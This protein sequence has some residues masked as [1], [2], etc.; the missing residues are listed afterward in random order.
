MNVGDAPL[1]SRIKTSGASAFE[2]EVRK[3]EDNPEGEREGILGK[4]GDWMYNNYTGNMSKEELAQMLSLKDVQLKVN[5]AVADNK[6]PEAV[7]D[8]E[9]VD[10]VIKSFHDS[11]Q[12]RVAATVAAAQDRQNKADDYD[13][14]DGSSDMDDLNK[15]VADSVAASQASQQ[16][17]QA[18]VGL[19]SSQAPSTSD[20][21]PKETVMSKIQDQMDSDLD[22]DSQSDSSVNSHVDLSA[23]ANDQNTTTSYQRKRRSREAQENSTT[24]SMSQADVTKLKNEMSTGFYNA[25]FKSEVAGQSRD[26]KSANQYM[27]YKY[28]EKAEKL[29]VKFNAKDKLPEL[30]NNGDKQSLHDAFQVMIKETQSQLGDQVKL[31]EKQETKQFIV[32]GLNQQIAGNKQMQEVFNNQAQA[33][34]TVGAN[35]RRNSGSDNEGSIGKTVDDGPDF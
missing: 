30:L 27:A 19:T 4:P 28:Y 22:H 5:D 33:T 9:S 6:K 26:L 14:D 32:D 10:D 7:N 8:K 25:N 17:N 18:D 34:A 2:A 24:T 11:F 35:K 31:F 16:N 21:K 29:G 12:E 15:S 3:H 1:M 13:F 20:A 23:E